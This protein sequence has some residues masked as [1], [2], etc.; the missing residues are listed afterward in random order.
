MLAV[1]L[2]PI[3]KWRHTAVEYRDCA[4][5]RATGAVT[6]Y[7]VVREVTITGLQ[8]GVVQNFAIR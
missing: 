3:T 1:A 2:G 8:D 6:S 5:L 7:P 4:L